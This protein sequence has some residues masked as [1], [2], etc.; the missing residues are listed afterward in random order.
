MKVS[1][2]LIIYICAIFFLLSEQ[3]DIFEFA[4]FSRVNPQSL[5][6]VSMQLT[7]VMYCNRK[8]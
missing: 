6:K 2:H 4:H 7:Q 8:D 1:H 3:S 5:L